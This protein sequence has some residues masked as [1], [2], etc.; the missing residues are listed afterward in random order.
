VTRLVNKTIAFKQSMAAE[1]TIWRC[2]WQGGGTVFSEEVADTVGTGTGMVGVC[3]FPGLSKVMDQEGA[4][5]I[6]R[7]VRARVVLETVLP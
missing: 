2:Y 5:F 6:L 7:V 3:V 1:S 4:E